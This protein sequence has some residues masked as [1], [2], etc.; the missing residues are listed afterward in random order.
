[1]GNL[2]AARIHE[3]QTVITNQIGIALIR[4]FNERLG[5]EYER[6][7]YFSFY[8]GKEVQS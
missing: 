5:S 8:P 3:L 4:G 1:M 7:M 6:I 2:F